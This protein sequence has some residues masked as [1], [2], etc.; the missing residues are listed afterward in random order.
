MRQRMI[1]TNHLGWQL[2]ET[3]RAVYQGPATDVVDEYVVL[4][5][6]D[7]VV[8]SGKAA[9]YGTVAHWHTGSY[10]VLDLTALDVAGTYRVR[11]ATADGVAVMSEPF[12]IGDRLVPFRLMNAIGYYYKG[13]RASGEWRETDHHLTFIGPK[14]GTVDVHGGWYDASGDY[15]VHM[16]HLSHSTWY[17]PQQVP[18]SAWALLQAYDR[19]AANGDVQYSMLQ[20]R[21]LDEGTYGAD[22]IRRMQAPSGNIYRSINRTDSLEAPQDSRFVSFEYHHSSDQFGEAVTAGEEQV[23]DTYYETSLR[24]GG[25]M[26]IAALAAAARHPY[27]GTDYTTDEYLTAAREAWDV[28]REHNA[29]Y[30]NDGK[31]NLLDAMCALMAATELYRTTGETAY[32]EEARA[33]AGQIVQYAVDAGDGMLRLTCDGRRPFFH[34][35]DEGLPVVALLN[36]ADAETDADK[37]KQARAAAVSLMRFELAITREDNPFGYARM[38]CCDA[39][40]N[41]GVQYFFPHDTTA[42]PWWQGENARIASLAAAARMTAEVVAG[43]AGVTNDGLADP[44]LAAELRNYAQ[45]QLDWILGCNPYDVCMMEGYGRNNIQYCFEDRCDFLNAPGGI[46]NGI[47]SGMEDEEDILLAQWSTPEI[48]DNWRWAE[49]WIPHTAWFLYAMIQE[50]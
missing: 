17:N 29:D 6:Q 12:A 33:E 28:L 2:G 48:T 4:N 15:G 40:G 46:C 1:L 30:T 10:W 5:E 14:E 49:Q 9:A 11:L 39:A 21:M 34:A 25:G 45:R 27:P 7:E 43:E 42:A 23:D 32:L 26:C 44:A 19:M 31:D 35:V 37:A 16:S 8:L 38:Y 50:I 3:K 18:F 36:Y 24:S 47:T 41:E 22:F 13:Q 20:E